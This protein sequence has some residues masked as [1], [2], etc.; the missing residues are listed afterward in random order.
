MPLP[1]LTVIFEHQLV[2]RMTVSG[3]I[4]T[5]RLDDNVLVLSDSS[6]SGHHGRF[7][8]TT[9]GWCYTDLGSSNGSLVAAGPRLG[10]DDV[11]VISEVTQILLGSTVL[12]FDPKG[13]VVPT[14]KRSQTTVSFE[15]PP[16]AD[17]H[18]RGPRDQEDAPPAAARAVG[19]DRAAAT[20]PAA[21]GTTGWG[22]AQ[23][24][25]AREGA[26]PGDR[27]GLHLPE[28][29]HQ[30]PPPRTDAGSIHE[31][32]TGHRNGPAPGH[33]P[34]LR[35]TRTP[36]PRMSSSAAPA[37]APADAPAVSSPPPAVPPKTRP[38]PSLSD[39]APAPRAARPRVLVVLDGKVTSHALEKSVNVIGRSRQCDVIIDDASISSRHAELSDE[40]GQWMVRDL[41]S[42][43]GTRL[44]LIRLS[45]AQ[46][47]A[48]HTHLIVG[49]ADLLFVLDGP[50]DPARP[51]ALDDEQFLGWLRHRRQ[52]TR[53]QATAALSA[54]RQRGCT[55]GEML[56]EQ[57]V[58]SPGSLTELS[59]NA[60]LKPGGTVRLPGYA[61]GL[62][63]LVV[64]AALVFAFSG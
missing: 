7:A 25:Q 21:G 52:L 41:G 37:P 35:P 64:A 45:E 28:H 48:T 49:V 36:A 42:T 22:A 1:T 46:R 38:V 4:T 47:L 13:D 44:G 59:H 20:N 29:A 27:P 24:A 26:V 58:L 40:G 32:K 34:A 2:S 54:A 17:V 53:A 30:S 10:Q 60:A 19:H 51:A 18:R 62:I 55:V 63:V 23:G 61:W 8:R 39:E 57:G 50:P 16:S 33:R 15:G 31:L 14:K 9:Q 3:P 6:V 56:V 43:N 11:F 5:G 12:E